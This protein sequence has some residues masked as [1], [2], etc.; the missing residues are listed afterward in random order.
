MNHSLWWLLLVC[1]LVQ[2]MAAGDT[3]LELD[4]FG[5]TKD[6][7]IV[8][9]G[10][11]AMWAFWVRN[12][13]RFMTGMG[14]VA[15]LHLKNMTFGTYDATDPALAN[16]ARFDSEGKFVAEQ[17]RAYNMLAC[18]LSSTSDDCCRAL[19]IA[20]EGNFTHLYYTLRTIF[21][22]VGV[23]AQKRAQD[24]FNMLKLTTIGG[25]ITFAAAYKKNFRLMGE[26]A[27]TGAVVVRTLQSKISS[28]IIDPM[29]FDGHPSMQTESGI[30]ATLE[31]KYQKSVADAG[32]ATV[33]TTEETRTCF[34]CGEKGHLSKN[35][36]NKAKTYEAPPRRGTPWKTGNGQW[37]SHHSNG[38]G[39]GRGRGGRGGGG[40]RN[41]GRGKSHYDANQG[42]YGGGQKNNFR[43]RT[44]VCG[45]CNKFGHHETEC[46]RKARDEAEA[47]EAQAY[48]TICAARV[49]PRTPLPNSGT[50][51]GTPSTT[52]THSAPNPAP[53]SLAMPRFN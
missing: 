31:Q 35:C 19:D 5:N 51:P 24:T 43:G 40:G 50:I 10:D 36:T 34:R 17:A 12:L 52:G 26:L 44:L 8:F 15:F 32:G 13:K 47:I 46:R 37:K 28:D 11:A 7:L 9:D 18:V 27:P 20:T 22:G 23:E 21:E 3:P 1:L 25:F 48:A 29:H 53:S 33:L 38:R 6:R 4:S 2:V 14:L 39:R 41:T 45:Y 42:R 30:W 16:I 49:A